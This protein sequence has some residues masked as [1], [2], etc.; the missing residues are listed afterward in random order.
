M[1]KLKSKLTCSY[2]AKIFIDPIELPCGD[3]ICRKHLSE[4]NVV[5]EN[6]I[7]CNTCTQE[8]QVK[9]ND[10]KSSNDLSKLLESQSYLSKEEISV[11]QKLEE[12]IREF[13]K[14][15]DEFTHN[16]AK[17]ESDVYDHFHEMIFKID[18]HRE[19]LKA[20]IDDIALEMIEKIKKYEKLNSKKLQE[21][22]LKPHPY[23][24]KT[25]SLKKELDD[26]E[27]TFRSPNLLIQSIK[28]MQLRQEESLNDIRFKL[29]E[30]NRVKNDLKATGKF[31]PNLSLFRVN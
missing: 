8:Y 17:L 22:I 13:F 12:S 1:L 14:I 28:D 31:M 18:E 26:V 21:N 11:K 27:E 10:F 7:K 6:E 5:K 19:R 3:S 29:N 23:S 4:R 30:I 20:K 15:Y 2:C 9:D 16:K 25:N 24:D